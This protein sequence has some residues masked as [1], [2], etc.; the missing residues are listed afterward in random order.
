MEKTIYVTQDVP[1]D[2]WYRSWRFFQGEFDCRVT[3]YVPI[4]ILEAFGMELDK[5]YKVTV[6]EIE[7]KYI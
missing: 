4:Y 6:E 5:T 7:Y 2:K 1:S 3:Q